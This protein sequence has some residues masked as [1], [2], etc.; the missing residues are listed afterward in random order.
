MNIGGTV[1]PVSAAQASY[2]RSE[3]LSA[4]TSVVTDLAPS[5]TV[6]FAQ[7]A[8][9]AGQDAGHAA[10]DWQNLSREVLIDPQAR[11]VIFRTLTRRAGRAAEPA[12]EEATL[13]L[14]AYQNAEL[15]RE[16]DGH[17]IERTI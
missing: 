4:R 1:K 6:T 15:K 13:K 17:V 14:K 16:A 3:S 2:A 10:L 9:A 7:N 5:Q 8:G 12:P 11:E